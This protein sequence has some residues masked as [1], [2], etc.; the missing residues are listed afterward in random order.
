MPHL[1][2]RETGSLAPA[3]AQRRPWHWS[4]R[5]ILIS[6]FPLGS[7]SLRG[8]WCS[9][10]PVEAPGQRENAHTGPVRAP[11]LSAECHT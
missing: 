11:Q 10:G 8:A 3:S 1:L 9:M 2:A 4:A 7:A 5:S 6:H